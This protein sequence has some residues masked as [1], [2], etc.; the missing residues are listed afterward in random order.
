MEIFW[1]LPQADYYSNN[2]RV[3][4]PINELGAFNL[5]F[6]ADESS[7]HGIKCLPRFCSSR[8]DGACLAKAYS[9]TPGVKSIPEID[10]RD[11]N[12]R[13][14][15]GD[16]QGRVDEIQSD[17]DFPI[18]RQSMDS[19]M[20]SAFGIADFE[21]LL[22]TFFLLGLMHTIGT[23]MWCYRLRNPLTD[24]DD[25]ASAAPGNVSRGMSATLAFAEPEQKTREPIET[26]KAPKS[27]KQ[28]N[29]P[30]ETKS[31]P[32]SVKLGEPRVPPMMPGTAGGYPGM[33]LPPG[34]FYGGFGSQLPG[35]QSMMF[36]GQHFGNSDIEAD[37]DINNSNGSRWAF[38]TS[39][40]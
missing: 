36:S 8:C 4:G 15:T 25:E 18:D 10:D 35:Q 38:P 33:M 21:S 32:K 22:L 34:A 6:P 19:A 23:I 31:A 9:T 27:V 30:V 24:L 39:E 13:L 14:G 1:F 12:D 28:T 5:G 20:D 7:S 29:V 26:K 11:V 40:I 37:G 3:A 16:I 2:P 17:D